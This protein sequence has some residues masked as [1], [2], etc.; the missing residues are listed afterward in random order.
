[1][2]RKL[3]A[4]ALSLIFVL[5]STNCKRTTSIKGVDVEVTFSED[6]LS[7]NLVTDMTFV[8][9]TDSEF[10]GMRRDYNV[11]VHFWHGDNL[12]FQ[13]DYFPETP[14]SKWVPNQEY[15]FTQR[16][17][18]PVF[19]DEFDPNFKG[20]ETL[21]LS[22]GFYSPYDKTGES[23]QKI[24]SRKLKVSPP[25]LDTPQVIYMHGWYGLEMNRDYHFKNW[26]WTAK[27]AKCIIDNPH[28][29]A[30]LIIKGEVN[31]RAIE[32]Q[33]VIFKIN[34]T[35]LDEFVPEQAIFEKTYNINKEKLGE[36]DD[37]YLTVATDKTFVPSE[38]FPDSTDDRELGVKISFIYFR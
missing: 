32:D 20:E 26:R 4:V 28:R 30:L 6:E 14:T 37:F 5:V 3:C 2:W 16:I 11:F 15:K 19:I 38:I 25:P 17:Y 27:Q 9:E 8:W 18:I 10:E 7:D 23:E 21:D 13:A 35:I 12:L 33:K 24:Y 34:E 31:K 36:D 22:V 1:M 29:D